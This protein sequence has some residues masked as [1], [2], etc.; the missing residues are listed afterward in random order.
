MLCFILTSGVAAS[1]KSKTQRSLFDEATAKTGSDG[2]TNPVVHELSG[3]VRAV[4]VTY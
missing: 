1:L 2:L 4:L 3:T